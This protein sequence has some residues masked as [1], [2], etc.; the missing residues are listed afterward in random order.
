[1]SERDTHF[2][3]F[4]KLLFDELLATDALD[5]VDAKRFWREQEKAEVQLLFAQRAYDL[6]GDAVIAASAYQANHCDEYIPEHR[7]IALVS[8]VKAFPKAGEG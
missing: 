3:N 5:I 2:Q 4:A 7:L 1:M 6:V 8:D